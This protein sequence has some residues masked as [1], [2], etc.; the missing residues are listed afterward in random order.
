[1]AV[2]R[3]SISLQ[4][5][6]E[7]KADEITTDLLVKHKTKAGMATL[8][9]GLLEMYDERKHGAELRKA[10]AELKKR[11]VRTTRHQNKT[12]AEQIL[13]PTPPKKKAAAKP[14]KKKPDTAALLK[15]FVQR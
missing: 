3:T 7:K 6:L 4:P 9:S 14:K 8:L 13:T 2:K 11:D 1:M 12:P 15:S 5:K 10:L